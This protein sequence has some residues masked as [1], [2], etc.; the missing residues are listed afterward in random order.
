MRKYFSRF[1][2]GLIGVLILSGCIEQPTYTESDKKFEAPKVI[3]SNYSKAYRKLNIMLSNLYANEHTKIQVATVSNATTGNLQMDIKH[4]IEGPLIRYLDNYTVIAYDPQ[5]QQNRQALVGPAVGATWGDYVI[6]G[7]IS[8]YQKGFYSEGNGVD[9]D[10]EF[11]EGDGKTTVSAGASG[12]LS[13][14]SLT[15]DLKIRNKTGVYDTVVTNS[16]ELLQRNRTA[17]IGVYLNS[18]GLGVSKNANMKQSTDHALKLV[19]EFSLIQL[20]GRFEQLPYWRCFT[21]NLTKDD[22]VIEDWEKYFN[23]AFADGRSIILIETIL[24]KFY[25]AP[26]TIINNDLN[27][28]E[29]AS[30]LSIKEYF[31]IQE[32]IFNTKDFYIALMEHIPLEELDIFK[33]ITYQRIPPIQKHISRPHQPVH[34]KQPKSQK[35]PTTV[36]LTPSISP[37]QNN[38]NNNS[39][40]DETSEFFKKAHGI[41]KNNGNDNQI[42]IY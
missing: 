23:T 24:S 31:H 30:L 15:V 40:D 27:N 39:Q 38:V 34:K 7:E 12:G 18:I 5:Y 37:T 11:G 6:V 13:K 26:Y 16:I 42:L 9:V 14:S 28:N 8:E 22:E 20:I 4:F 35:L 25:H 21:P 19:S 17:N 32:T 1:L 3:I 41:I 2:I 36:I 29:I 10:G 33:T